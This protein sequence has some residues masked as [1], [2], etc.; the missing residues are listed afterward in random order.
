M[1]IYY[2]RSNE[3]IYSII[4]YKNIWNTLVILK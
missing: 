1:N 4:A 3:N 2:T